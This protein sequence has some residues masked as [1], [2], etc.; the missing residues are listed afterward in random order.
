MGVKNNDSI[1][2]KRLEVIN[3]IP[4]LPEVVERLTVLLQNPKTSAEEVG[5]AITADQALSSK[6][7]KLVNS[8]FYGFPGRI[9]SINHAVVILGFATVKNIVLTASILQCFKI[10][11]KKEGGFSPEQFWLH[12]ISCGAA[13]KC[14]ARHIGFSNSEECFTAGLIHDIGK[15]I[16][17]QYLPENFQQIIDLVNQTDKLFYDC[18]RELFDFTHQDIGGELADRWKLPSHL[19]DAIALHHNP[20][21]DQQN[22]SVTAVVHCADIFVR[23]L[24]YGS[25]ADR[26]IPP[27]NESVWRNLGLENTSLTSLFDSIGK[28]IRKASVF[29]QAV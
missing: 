13:A 28:E 1:L 19:R 20:F 25:G 16:L 24:N 10:P 12:S 8:A 29:V 27:M 5:R 18:E 26:K 23:A 6:V 2:S 21:I 22:F 7:L 3:S 15:I 9:G 4:T 17:H 14:I 11:E